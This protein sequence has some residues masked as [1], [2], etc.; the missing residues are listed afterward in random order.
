MKVFVETY[1]CQMNEYDVKL[2][3]AI[4]AGTNYFFSK[5]I[6]NLEPIDVWNI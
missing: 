1:G 5:N 2:A 3:L 4:G 6:E